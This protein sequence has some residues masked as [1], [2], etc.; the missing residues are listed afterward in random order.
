MAN[1]E[2][3]RDYLKRVTADLQQTRQRLLRAEARH[4]EPV[5]IVGMACRYPGGA[6]SPEDLWRLIAD[7]GDAIS[8]FPT[9]RDW[10]LN[11]L[12]DPDPGRSG[13]CYTRH[14]GFL[15]DADEFD[16]EFFGVHPREALA[17]D[18]QQRLLLQTGWEALERA[19]ID[20]VSL[21]GSHTG[22]FAGVMYNDYGSRFSETPE[23]YDG[24]LVNG[25]A[26]SVASGRVAYTFGFEGPAV[27]VDT[28]CSSSLVAL[29]LA[30]QALRRRECELALAGGVSVM[31]T[32]GSLVDF[33]RQR[34]LAEDGR[35]KAFSAAAD[36]TALGE[37][38]GLLLLERLA[39]AR[40]NGHPVLAVVRG[41]AVNQDGASSQLTA[42]NGPSQER[43]IRQALADARLTA[44][45]IDAVEAHGTGTTLGDPIEARA[46]QATYGRDRPTGRPLWLGSVK[47]NIGHAQAAAGVAGVIKMVMAMR[48]RTLPATLHVDRPSPHVDWNTADV[49]LLTARRAWDKADAPRRAGVSSFG[50]SGTNAHVVLEEPT[51]ETANE[52][53]PTSTTATGG[54]VPWV[55]SARGATG[56]ARQAARLRDRLATAPETERAADIGFSLATTRAHL[57]HRAV[58]VAESRAEFTDA[59]TALADGVPH[60]R[61]LTGRSTGNRGRVAFLFP[62]ED[63]HRPGAGR[64]LYAS[65][66]S[67]AAA[68]DTVCARLDH[69]FG[70]ALPRPLREVLL[71]DPAVAPGDAVAAR[72]ALFAVEIALFRLFESWNV[73]PDVL[74]GHGVGELAAAHASGALSLDDA[75]A[76]VAAHGQAELRTAAAAA[77]HGHIDIPFVSCLTGH[78]VLPEE[79]ASPDHWARLADDP[80]HLPDAVRC[81]ADLDITRCAVLGPGD[82][83]ALRD[84]LAAAG[85]ELPVVAALSQ[86]ASE[87]HAVLATLAALHLDGA[88]AD[89]HAVFATAGPRRVEL[90][91]YAFARDRHWLSAPAPATD[92]TRLGLVATGHPLLGGSLTLADGDGIVV[93]GRLARDTHPWL[94]DH[95]VAGAV[96]LSGTSFVEMAVHAGDQV[97]CGQLQELLLQ[98]PLL[99]PERGAVHTQILV[100][101]PDETGRRG[102][103]VHSRPE[104]ADPDAPWTQHASGTLS[105]T[106]A[107]A[108]RPDGAW[109]PAGAEPAPVDDLYDTLAAAGYHY[110][111]TFRGLRAAWRH[112]TR[113]HAEVALPDGGTSG[114]EAA[115]YGLHPALLDAA[116]HGFALWRDGDTPLLVPFAW[117]GV[118]LHAAH[119]TSLRVTLTRGDDGTISLTATDP[120]GVPV[121]S[122]DALTVRPVSAGQLAGDATRADGVDSLYRVSW[123]PLPGADTVPPAPAE[124]AVVTAAGDPARAVTDALRADGVTV[125]AH[126][127]IAALRAAMR[128]GRTTPEVVL[129]PCAATGPVPDPAAAHDLTARVLDTVQ[130]WLATDNLAGIP[131]AILTRGATAQDT[132]AR[133]DPAQ[134]AVWGLCRAT[135]SEHTD[136]E[137]RLLLVDLPP[138]TTDAGGLAAAV[139]TAR[140]RN[141]P[142]LMV[143]GDTLAAPRLTRLSGERAAMV[144]PADA[145]AWRLDSVSTGTLDSLALIPAPEAA[146]PLAA[147][148]VRI[149]VHAA[150]LNFRD[151]L[152]ALGVVPATAAAM[153]GEGAGVVV[154]TA[155][156]VTGLAPGDRVMGMVPGFFGPLAVAD[157]HMVTRIPDGLTF[158]QAASLPIAY[159]T[160]HLGLVEVARLAPG[161]TLLVH[162]GAGGVG[163]AAIQLARHLG[164]EVFATASESKW[165][166]LRQLGLDDHHIASSRTLEFEQRFRAVTGGRGVDVVLDSL[167]GEFVDASLRLLADGGRFAEM[168]K[169]DIRDPRD[170]ADQYPHISR[171][172]AFDL[173]GASPEKIRRLLTEVV[174]LVESGAVHSLPLRTWDIRRAPEAFRHMSQARHTG[175]IVLT[176]PRT[177]DPAGTVLVTGGTGGLGALVARHLVT[178]HGARHLLLV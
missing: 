84:A 90:P 44:A 30:A 63:G 92:A 14:G 146:G 25:S 88:T 94:A 140:A 153:G 135:Q 170:V 34:G 93:T 163:M 27:T 149:A 69:H 7:G 61:L 53:D 56:L 8:P 147:G 174:R 144:P 160:A 28:A 80:G 168:G 67:F 108:F 125:R 104:D 31:S 37:G 101:A 172:E 122:V 58:I 145:P 91:T 102:L 87:P 141:E 129:L 119:A 52:A 116:L 155:E 13:T 33:S 157:Q 4:H 97:G 99:L 40:R 57:S 123:T 59:L 136:G 11:G 51:P 74:L 113:V 10:D 96:I 3:L 48:H 142:Q 143:R 54:P 83:N 24:Y 46:L 165:D 133:V 171:Y 152:I 85:H 73:R 32:P 66:P 169:T 103:A 178:E 138:D 166:A 100:T 15:D 82:T 29:H 109:P 158:E 159:M 76:L 154:E 110:G 124:W 1:E 130:R 19:G 167:T 47:S 106:T 177:A 131:L 64:E 2:K 68:F 60:P 41:S 132:A 17:M 162:A 118:T 71:T 77:A 16:A 18:P 150:G 81:L 111:P 72:A 36:G 89:W 161:E 151:V 115:R 49:E 148:Q 62:G 12:Y 114:A 42:P 86:T 120:A 121:I 127:D 35:V 21:R 173:L 105:P 9:T 65:H 137:H 112:G 38:A 175:K 70:A 20:P 5:A 117:S 39:D 43:V 6:R 26:G 78:E 164:A 128:D 22:V 98:T 50:I 107:P 95:A 55:L 23:G 176:M 79:L 134:A 126:Q 45:D 156:D 75:C 139:A